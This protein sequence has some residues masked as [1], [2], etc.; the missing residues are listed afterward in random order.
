MTAN[1]P[2]QTARKKGITFRDIS[3]YLYILPSLILFICFVFYP[4]V[5]TIVLSLQR[6]GQ[7]GQ[8]HRLRRFPELCHCIQRQKYVGRHSHHV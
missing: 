6:H 7:F 2:Q 4:F 3:P 1:I 5:K 8:Y